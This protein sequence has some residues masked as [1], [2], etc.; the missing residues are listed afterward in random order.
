[1]SKIHLSKLYHKNKNQIKVDFEYD[2]NVKEYIKKYPLVK[3]S[4]TYKTF[5]LPFSKENAN[6]FCIYLRKNNYHV[7]FK[8]LQDGFP[9]YNLSKQLNSEIISSIDLFK[10]WLIQMRYSN[11]TIKT[12]ISMIKLFFRFHSQK[13]IDKINVK[14]IELF[15]DQYIIKNNFSSTFQNQLI[16]AIKLFYSYNNNKHLDLQNLNRPKKSKK[17]PEVLSLDDIKLILTSIKNVKHK[18]LLSLIYSCGLRI[19]EA[20]N[21]RIN[22]IDLNRKLLHIKSAKGRKDRFVPISLTMID[23]LKKYFSL[24]NPKL[25]LFEGQK[26]ATYSATSARQVLKRALNKTNINKNVTLHTLRHSYAT[27]LLE[28]G[29]DIRFIQEL[30]G[31]NSPKTTMIYTHV[32]T[33]SLQKI[34][35]PFDDFNI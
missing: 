18:T 1:M 11:N 34:K 15:N 32:S 29:T 2:Y 30:L 16:N 3:W 31:H 13:D 33:I 28:N 21:L 22:S 9:N 8:K 24:Y 20:L 17:L 4:N 10:R 27:H 7:D 26:N 25:Y 12:Y 19:G 35:N 5:Y 23:L 6:N 14:D